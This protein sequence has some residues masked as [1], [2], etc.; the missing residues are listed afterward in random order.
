[1]RKTPS[2]DNHIKE[3]F[4]D[5]SPDVPAHIWENILAEKDRRKPAAWWM[6]NRV[7]AAALLLL[8]LA[9]TG[10]FVFRHKNGTVNITTLPE[11][12]A[13]FETQKTSTPSA[14]NA[15]DIPSVNGSQVN[16]TG[17]SSSFTNDPPT[18]EK[19]SQVDKHH[20]PSEQRTRASAAMQ[21]QTPDQESDADVATGLKEFAQ[22]ESLQPDVL[23]LAK[24]VTPVPVL[25]VTKPPYLPFAIIPCPEIERNA[26]ANKKYVELYAGP[27]Y[28]MSVF[29]D[30]AHSAYLQKRKETTKIISAFSAGFRYTRV[31]NNG[32]SLRTG[33]NYSQINEKFTYVQGHVVQLNYYI[34]NQGD[35][36]GTY[37][38]TGTRYKSGINRYR[39]IDVPIAMGYEMGNDRVHININAGVMVNIYSWQKG[40]MVDEA[41]NI[42]NITTGKTN[43]PYGFKS[44][45]GLGLT[46]GASFY[47]KL[48]NRMHLLAEPYFRYNLSQATRSEL[49]LKQKYNT[50]GLRLGLRLDL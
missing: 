27:D 18:A 42:I 30:T 31:F 22:E 34:N 2:F 14:N 47:Y 29:A 9:G 41:D 26:A 25:T 39:Y 49:S 45:I 3:Q 32:M 28:A 16:T 40:S 21:L 12:A 35:T 24:L 33:I 11:N 15:G 44:N 17:D 48:T 1:M 50:A 8:L 43:S 38:E 46:G 10:L 4:S 6:R 5:Y 23:S 19:L 20:K 7:T 37:S 13:V 36:T